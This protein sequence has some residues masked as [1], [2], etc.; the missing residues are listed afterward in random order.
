[1]VANFNIAVYTCINF[2]SN[3]SIFVKDINNAIPKTGKIRLAV[4]AKNCLNIYIA[5]IVRFAKYAYSKCTIICNYIN[6]TVFNNLI[7]EIRFQINSARLLNPAYYTTNIL[8]R[9]INVEVFT[10]DDRDCI[11]PINRSI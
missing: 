8:Y 7:V 3:S 9:H 6:I 5:D 2:G 10:T 4:I 1:M 11:S